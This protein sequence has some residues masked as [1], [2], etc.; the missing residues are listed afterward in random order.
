MKWDFSK[1]KIITAVFAIATFGL[2]RIVD[3]PYWF[4]LG[5]MIVI[6]GWG[7]EIWQFLRGK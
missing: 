1:A 3:A 5:M 6:A 4:A 2:L 7:E